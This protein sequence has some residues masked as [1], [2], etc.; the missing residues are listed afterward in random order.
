MCFCLKTPCLVCMK[1]T[2]TELII[3]SSVTPAW[4]SSSNA[5]FLHQA[6]RSLFELSNTTQPF[7]T[8]FGGILNSKITQS[9][10]NWARESKTSSR[11]SPYS[12]WAG[13]RTAGDSNS[14]RSAHARVCEPAGKRQE[15]WSGGL[16]VNVSK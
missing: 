1:V 12:T 13:T 4:I 16:Q 2:N 9:S 6:T 14:S 3:N 7:S 5:H 11:A 10:T 15:Y 8:M